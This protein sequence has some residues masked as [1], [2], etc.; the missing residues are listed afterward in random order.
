MVADFKE[1]DLVIFVCRGFGA[2]L[3]Q[4]SL[5]ATCRPDLLHFSDSDGEYCIGDPIKMGEAQ[6]PSSSSGYKA[7]KTLEEFVVLSLTRSET[8]LSVRVYTA[9]SGQDIFIIYNKIRSHF[10]SNS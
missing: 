5:L 3:N 1:F 2:G 4:N 10:E 7:A 9:R 8:V 6:Q